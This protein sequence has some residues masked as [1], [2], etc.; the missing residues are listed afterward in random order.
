MNEPETHK[1]T[2]TKRPRPRGRMLFFALLLVIV[3][4]T[5]YVGTY[6]KIVVH[7]A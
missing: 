1:D 7:G 4:V 5:M 3:V 6:Y 2:P